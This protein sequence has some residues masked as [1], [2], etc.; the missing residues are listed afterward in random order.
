M[1]WFMIKK[2]G[3][4]WWERHYRLLAWTLFLTVLIFMLHAVQLRVEPV[5]RQAARM[6]G[7]RLLQQMIHEQVSQSLSDYPGPF[8]NVEYGS[9]GNIRS[10]GLDVPSVNALKTQLTI[11]LSEQ[12]ENRSGTT[13]SIP[14]G[15]IFGGALLHGRG[16]ALPFVICP[17]SYAEVSFEQDF[18]SA[19]INQ[20]VYRVRLRVQASLTGVFGKRQTVS[21]V[22][23][24][25]L[26]EE[27]LI[28]GEV[29]GV[30]LGTGKGS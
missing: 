13:L 18:S 25:F 14:L 15:T 21:Q 20:T 23:T 12:L 29:P 11:A 22:D 7:T 8:S 16:P 10:V 2:L 24:S 30:Y 28:A 19:G 6:E 26:L 5:F 17:Y 3:R 27:R 9:D 4:R 1:S